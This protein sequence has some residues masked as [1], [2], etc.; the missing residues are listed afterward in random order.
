[1]KGTL[2]RAGFG[3]ALYRLIMVFSFMYIGISS[4]YSQTTLTVEADS[5]PEYLAALGQ[6][7][8]AAKPVA[9]ENLREDGPLL[10]VTPDGVLHQDIGKRLSAPD[11][12]LAETAKSVFRLYLSLGGQPGT[13]ALLLQRT[14][15]GLFVAR[16]GMTGRLSSSAGA[17]MGGALQSLAAADPGL[18]MPVRTWLPQLTSAMGTPGVR[19][20]P[21][22]A[23]RV[24]RNQRT[25]INLSGPEITRAGD[26]PILAG[27]PGSMINIVNTGAG[28]LQASAIFSQNVPEGFTKLY[29]YRTG[30][31]LTPIASFDVSV[32]SGRAGGAGPESDDHGG[33]P[34]TATL[35]LPAGAP[36]A[37]ISGQIGAANDVDM[38]AL[39]VSRPGTLAIRSLGS[40]DVTAQLLDSRGNP[41]ASDDDGGK[42]YNFGLQTA[43]NPGSYLLAVRHCCGGGGNYE[44]DTKLTP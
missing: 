31:A 33:A 1:M 4:P 2:I 29:L 41:V 20:P 21:Y 5:S 19:P 14:K 12:A 28:R 6:L 11:R 44:I 27:P 24:A 43:V 10:R 39:R 9:A 34:G 30:D 36:G 35:L 32:G 8:D 15:K 25:L 37:H 22:P 26:H 13:R 17:A 3:Q 38:F 7:F 16:E 40:S 42:G 23:V 18:P